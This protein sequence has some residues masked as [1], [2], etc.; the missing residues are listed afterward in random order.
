VSAE[1][2]LRALLAGNSAVAAL[3]GTAVAHNAIRQGV[4]APYVVFTC[5]HDPQLG[6]LSNL[7][8]DRCSFAVQCWGNTAGQA[9]AVADAVVAAVGTAPAAH[10]A[11]ITS[12]ASGYDD[13]TG[14]DATIL[15]VEWWA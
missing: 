3:V 5:A 6:L 12:R 4:P 14:L 11:C 15:S 13:E 1:T 9:E 7:L 10:G 8:A 2:A